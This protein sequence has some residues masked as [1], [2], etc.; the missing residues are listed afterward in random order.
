MQG[1]PRRPSMRALVVGAGSV[2]GYFGGRLAAAGR[3]VTF[4]VHPRRATQLAGK[5]TISSQGEETV[6]PIN[7]I[8]SGEAAGEFDV[9]LLAVK[10]YQ[11]E[12]GIEDFGAVL[13][14][15]S[16]SVA[17]RLQH[18]VQQLGLVRP[19]SGRVLS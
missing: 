14:V 5:L 3:D 12:D 7:S 16:R 2:G 11:L 13:V 1:S 6:V 10:A 18:R 8:T 4:L 9:V 17:H 19:T 15:P